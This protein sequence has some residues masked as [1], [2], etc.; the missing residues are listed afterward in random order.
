MTCITMHTFCPRNPFG[1]ELGLNSS[2]VCALKTAKL[3]GKIMKQIRC[4][5]DL[6]FFHRRPMYVI[7]QKNMRNQENHA[8]IS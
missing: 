6:V 5:H 4:A 2:A 8:I 1:M 7:F 3:R